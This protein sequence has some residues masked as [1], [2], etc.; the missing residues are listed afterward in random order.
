MAAS[1]RKGQGGKWYEGVY[2]WAFSPVVP[3]TG[4]REDR[5]RVPRSIVGFMNA[6]LLTGDDRYM[7]VWRR[8]NAAINCAR[9]GNR[10]QVADAAHVRARRAGTAT[11]RGRIA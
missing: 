7:A 3:Q 8:Q 2:G 9:E 4:K 1:A 10:R 11:R 5:N 6:A